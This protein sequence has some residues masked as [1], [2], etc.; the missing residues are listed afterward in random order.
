MLQGKKKVRKSQRKSDENSSDPG[1]SGNPGIVVITVKKNNGL[2]I[3][4]DRGIQI[5]NCF[6]NS[7]SVSSSVRILFLPGV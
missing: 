1:A 2:K 3:M 5:K 6:I 7:S 4:Y